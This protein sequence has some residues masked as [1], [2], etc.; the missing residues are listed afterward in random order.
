MTVQSSVQSLLHG[1]ATN[2][3]SS[4][5]AV[6]WPMFEKN[7]KLT[8]CFM[9]TTNFEPIVKQ[10][11]ANNTLLSQIFVNEPMYFYILDLYFWTGKNWD[12]DFYFWTEGVAGP[13]L[14]CRLWYT[15]D[16]K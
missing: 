7:D 6:N 4:N 10:S 16:V 9:F 8:K 3:C 15:T 1:D 14:P 11:V 5:S 2:D 12:L 13:F